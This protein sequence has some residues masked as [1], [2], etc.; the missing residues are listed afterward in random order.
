MRDIDYN[1]VGYRSAPRPRENPLDVGWGE[2]I[3][4]VTGYLYYSGEEE[5]GEEYVYKGEAPGAVSVGY[6][7]WGFASALE[8]A[9]VVRPSFP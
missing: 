4:E 7:A 8:V 2:V 3:L 5:P 6:R 9:S 1:V